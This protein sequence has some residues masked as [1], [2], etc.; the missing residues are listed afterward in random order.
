M[1]PALRAPGALSRDPDPSGVLCADIGGTHARLACYLP[2]AGGLTDL[3]VV[4]SGSVPG[5]LE[6]I[7]A[8]EERHG[9]RPARI[10][11]GIAG[12]IHD[13]ACRLTN[14]PWVVDGRALSRDLGRP[15]RLI[16]DFHALARAVPH[17]GPAD[18]A[19]LRPGAAVP[20][21][22]V[23][24]IGPG[25][26][27]GE[28]Y[29]AH[30]NVLPGEGGHAGFAPGDDRERRLAGWLAEQARARPGGQADPDPHVCWEDALSGPGLVRLH[31][32]LQAER[33]LPD[34]A[35]IGDPDAPARAAADPEVAAWFWALLAAE[36]GDMALRLLCRGG[37]Y[38]CGG[39]PPKLRHAF[40]PAAFARRFAAKGPLSHALDGVPVW[41]VLHPEPGLLG[42]AAEILAAEDA[43]DPAPEPA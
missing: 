42:A 38:V 2:G 29:L 4:P 12:P 21:A 43:R 40:D 1:D 23:A 34:P 8:W 39:I 31:R 18:L 15:V 33:G 26:G 24:V 30:G 25:T 35:W 19:P 37:V 14:L 36:A 27:L 41:L 11:L 20:G 28:A 16:N 7:R 5:M 6:L 17:L 13:E 22:P 10:C 3:E 9:R 32:F